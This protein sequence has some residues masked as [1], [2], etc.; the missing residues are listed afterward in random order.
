VTTPDHSPST[1]WDAAPLRAA[2]QTTLGEF[3]DAQAA[4]LAELGA[5]A[6]R[7]VAAAREA[8]TGGKRFR[9]AFCYWGFRAVKD[10]GYD[11]RQLVRAAAALEL[12]HAS[13]L[14]HDDYMDASD[15]RRGRP[16]TH[17]AFESQH[18]EQGWG[19]DPEQY[20][21]AA[22]I[23]LA[24]WLA[25]RRPWR[26]TAATLLLACGVLV[27]REGLVLAA[28]VIAAALVATIPT[29]RTAWPR[30]VLAGAIVAAA[31][32]PWRLWYRAHGIEGET[33]TAWVDDVWS[34]RTVDSLRL[35][36][37][38]L[39]ASGR[40][41]VVPTIGVAAV[42]LAAVWGRRSHAAYTGVLVALLTLAGASTSVVFTDIGVTDDEAVN[43][44]V[45]LTAGTV[46]AMSCLTPLLLA[47]VW[48][49]RAGRANVAAAPPDPPVP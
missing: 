30:L 36:V 40:W 29:R 25:D 41:S 28:C 4:R 42:V 9:A 26:L 33:G 46:L 10:E 17:R 35:A 32:L 7:L 38:V 15:V 21:A 49:G 44:I 3:V 16:A 34:R 45:R 20:G 47:G 24:L 19:G 1:P 48:A 37:D 6:D 11:E 18:R 12:L 27:K 31:A 8:I 22:A 43:P 23:L 5:D 39:A 2:V 14:V 13:A